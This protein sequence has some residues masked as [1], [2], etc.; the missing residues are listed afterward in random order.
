M[1]AQMNALALTSLIKLGLIALW[2]DIQYSIYWHARLILACLLSVMLALVLFITWNVQQTNY[3]VVTTVTDT[4]TVYRHSYD[5]RTTGIV[6][7]LTGRGPLPES[8]RLP[9]YRQ[10]IKNRL[11]EVQLEVPEHFTS[12]TIEEVNGVAVQWYKHKFPDH[13]KD[14]EAIQQLLDKLFVNAVQPPLGDFTDNVHD[15]LWRLLGAVGS[16]RIRWIEEQDD[17]FSRFVVAYGE[18]DKQAFYNPVNHTIYITYDNAV[19][20]LLDEV[21]HSKQF[22]DNPYQSH[23]RMMGSMFTAWIGGNFDFAAAKDVYKIRYRHAHTF[24][25][26]AHGPVKDELLREFGLLAVEEHAPEKT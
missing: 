6:N 25:G 15:N 9:L 14:Q 24:E 18:N 12:F 16:P 20:V 4:K 2:S 1:E 13:P 11:E 10:Y 17:D 5:Q 22:R 7:Y 23:F 3:T 26:E 19:A 8:E 21:C